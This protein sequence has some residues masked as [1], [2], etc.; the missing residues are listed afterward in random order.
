MNV[1]HT[2]ICAIECCKNKPNT[3]LNGITSKVIQRNA[4]ERKKSN[5]WNGMAWGS[6]CFYFGHYI[7]HWCGHTEHI[8]KL[9]FTHCVWVP[10]CSL[11]FYP[12]WFSLENM[13]YKSS[14]FSQFY[15]YVFMVPHLASW[16]HE[17]IFFYFEYV[18]S[19][20]SQYIYLNM[21]TFP[22]PSHMIWYLICR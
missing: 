10:L 12:R 14:I 8:H 3:I 18:V 7:I 11:M 4:F 15:I 6:H 16:W 2:F 19:A 1:I 22:F 20:M 5:G 17:S 13:K 9:V 21:K